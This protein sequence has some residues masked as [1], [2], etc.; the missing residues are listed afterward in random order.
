MLAATA[1]ET[2]CQ[3][4]NKCNKMNIEFKN[5]RRSTELIPN[6][7]SKKI[8]GPSNSA[9]AQMTAPN[10]TQQNVA[11]HND[12][13][14]YFD[15]NIS[16]YFHTQTLRKMDEVV[17][18]VTKPKCSL[19]AP[20]KSETRLGHCFG[21]SQYLTD[22][23]SDEDDP[24]MPGQ[25]Y[26]PPPSQVLGTQSNSIA[27]EVMDAANISDS[28]MFAIPAVP[29]LP[30]PILD[31]SMNDLNTAQ[32]LLDDGNDD[33]FESSQFLNDVK[34]FVANASVS[35]NFDDPNWSLTLTSSELGQLCTQ[36]FV[37]LKSNKTMN[38]YLQLQR[39]MEMENEENINQDDFNFDLLNQST[40]FHRNVEDTFNECERTIRGLDEFERS[41]MDVGE[42]RQETDH[43][44][45]D[46][47]LSDFREEF[48]KTYLGNGNQFKPNGEAITASKPA[49][50]LPVPASNFCNLGPFFGLPNRVKSLIR[51][52][53]GIDDLYGKYI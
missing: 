6:N 26:I 29:D 10:A 2:K 19:I 30:A 46:I 53:K 33:V 17:N 3:C 32:F 39:S 47:N 9:I 36:N 38:E 7:N 42:I 16:Q 14:R 22:S 27:D 11:Q 51:E 20:Q 31:T 13:Y 21:F 34:S 48:D 25:R 45:E 44:A 52:F 40:Q 28:A 4:Q 41:E 35:D 37:V 50:L 24:V 8:A 23:D 49:K 5:K 18:A 43:N 1:I 12:N 15:D